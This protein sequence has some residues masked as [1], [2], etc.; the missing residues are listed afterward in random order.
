M[1]SPHQNSLLLQQAV[2]G[3]W[4]VVAKA[5]TIDQGERHQVSEEAVEGAGTAAPARKG[6][7]SKINIS[8]SAFVMSLTMTGISAYYALRGSDLV[9]IAPKQVILF[10]D[11]EG[12][13]SVLSIATRFDVINASADYGDVLLDASVR[14]GKD[15]PSFAYSAPV[16][17]TFTSRAAE[18]ANGC[19][20]DSRC[21][22]LTGLLVVEQPDEM[23]DLA[24]GAAR[25]LTLSFPAAGWNCSSSPNKCAGYETFDKALAT[26]GDRPI[27]LDFTIKFNSDGTRRILCGASSPDKS[28]LGQAG[29]I[30][31][32][33][34]SRKVDGGPLF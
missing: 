14:I 17:A 11:G 6:W 7:R 15:G 12:A 20:I 32:P 18:A 13:G 22:P 24:G 1:Q 16:K 28:Y 31:L 25:T 29:W 4:H 30:S 33:C 5:V 9:V 10:R 19:A 34:K 21:I 27:D 2:L 23:I 26:M 8:V 3:Q